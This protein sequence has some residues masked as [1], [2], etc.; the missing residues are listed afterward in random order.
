MDDKKIYAVM[1][2]A[3]GEM[4]YEDIAHEVG[5]TGK[6]LRI[7]R[8][9]PAFAQAV[10][11]ELNLRLKDELPAIYNVLI[12]KCLKGSDQAIR[13]LFEHLRETDKMVLDTMESA[14]TIGWR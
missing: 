11:D 9:E 7:W 10:R 2:L 13:I 12:Q 14:F 4:N 3:A 5:V 8:R 1:L 6:T